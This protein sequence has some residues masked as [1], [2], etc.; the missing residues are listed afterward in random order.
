ML[1]QLIL[2]FHFILGNVEIPPSSY[3]DSLEELWDEQE[4]PE[5]METVMK[6]VPSTYH[7]DLDLLSK[8]KAEK[9]PPHHAC[10]NHIELDESLPPAKVI[11]S[12][13]NKKSDTLRA[14]ISESLEKGFIWSS[15][16][17]KGAPFLFAKMKDG[18]LHLCVYYGKVKPVTRKNKYPIP[19]MNHL[20]TFFNGSSIFSIIDL[21]G[22]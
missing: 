13:S 4:E 10:D 18:G 16:S 12:L 15:S 6:A 17:S 7:Q 19:P 11:Y 14:Y 8:V 2:Y 9:P 1:E 3:H 5:E 22:A 20:L 21:C